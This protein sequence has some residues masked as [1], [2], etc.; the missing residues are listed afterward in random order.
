VRPRRADF[1]AAFLRTFAI[2]GSWNYET[3]IGGGLAYALAPLLE[4]IHAGDPVALRDAVER[5]SREFNAHPYLSPIAVGALA[6]LELEG[7]EPATI[8]RFR[9]ALR[10]PLG[11][12]GDQAIWAAWRPLCTMG[13]IVAHLVLGLGPALAAV[14]FLF[15]Y[16]LGHIGLRLWGFQKGWEAG[17]DVGGALARSGLQ[18]AGRRLVPLNQILIGVVAVFLIVRA[19][20]GS[21]DVPIAAI[22]AGTALGGY[23]AP[24]RA[25]PVAMAGLFAAWLLWPF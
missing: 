21:I 7:E 19:P 17:L 16:N 22:A 1:L 4:R 24:G 18:R 23:L 2:Q 20:G 15:V 9:T 25:A 3:M 10:G 11:A 5:H 12:V 8:E 6:R 13:A 14:L